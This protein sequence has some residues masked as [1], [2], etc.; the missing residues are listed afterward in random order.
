MLCADSAPRMVVLG[1]LTLKRQTPTRSLIRAREKEA[2]LRLFL[3]QN[4]YL[5]ALLD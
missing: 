4:G 3:G 5:Q 2:I 1:S